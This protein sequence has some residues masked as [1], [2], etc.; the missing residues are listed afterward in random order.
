MFFTAI[1]F[2]LCIFLAGL[3]VLATP[4][5]MSPILYFWIRTLKA[6][7]ASGRAT[8]LATHL[9]NILLKVLSVSTFRKGDVPCFWSQNRKPVHYYHSNVLPVL[10]S[11]YQGGKKTNHLELN[12]GNRKTEIIFAC[13]KPPALNIQLFKRF[14]C[15]FPFPRVTLDRGSGSG[16]RTLINIGPRY[17]NLSAGT[18]WPKAISVPTNNPFC[19]NL[20]H[21]LLRISH[22]YTF[23]CITM[24]F[25]KNCN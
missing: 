14:L 13:I 21:R 15:F 9:P 24:E 8:N 25:K 19:Q 4:L 1:S 10:C 3:S 7:I 18:V 22:N 2:F 17:E 5:L 23:I 6:V 11:V 12:F 20:P 16:S